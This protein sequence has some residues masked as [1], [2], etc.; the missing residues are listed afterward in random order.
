MRI[1]VVQ[2]SD[3]LEKGPHQSHHLM[4]RMSEKGHEIRVIDF[5]I[6]W[7]KHPKESVYS[8][9]R[10]FLGIHKAIEK[11]SI[12]VIRPAIIKMPILDY[13]SLIITHRK[14]IKRQIKEF[15]P[16]VIIGFGILNSNLAIRISKKSEIPFVYYVIDELHRLIPQ[17]IFQNLGNLIE[18]N[19]MVRSDLVLSINEGLREYTID[20]GARSEET[21]VIR[22][23]IDFSK[24]NPEING[25]AVREKYG[26]REGEIVLFFMGWLYDFSGLKEIM[27]ELTKN[28][29]RYLNIRLLIIGKGDLWEVIEQAINKEEMKKKVILLDWQPY[30]KMPEFLG[31]ADICILPALKNEI[32]KNIVPIKIYEYMAMGKPVIVTRLSGIIREF[33]LMSGITYID[34]PEEAL[35]TAIRMSESG[36]IAEMG[37]QAYSFVHG[38]D[39]GRITNDFESILRKLI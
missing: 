29:A 25:S 5:E 9:R 37:E 21:S 7:R 14:E 33:G 1:L 6:L 31:A 22:A 20:M 19:N 18:K 30:E 23:G 34:R 39:W 16:D 8:Q 12:T 10:I 26:I 32:M 2:E 13:L 11:G 3:W 38:N 35:Q 15:V 4:E 17:D 27:E 36:V 28:P 24:F